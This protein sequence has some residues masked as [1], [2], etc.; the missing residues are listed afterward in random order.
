[1]ELLPEE[2]DQTEHQRRG[3]RCDGDRAI[4]EKIARPRRMRLIGEAPDVELRIV[5]EDQHQCHGEGEQQGMTEQLALEEGRAKH[6][7]D[8]QQEQRINGI[9]HGCV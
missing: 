1:V 8:H 5:A 2:P 3:D 7:D 4:G 6:V 9:G